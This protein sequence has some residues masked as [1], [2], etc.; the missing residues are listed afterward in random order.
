MSV[1]PCVRTRIN[2]VASWVW[3]WFSHHLCLQ[4]STSPTCVECIES[5]V[6]NCNT[7]RTLTSPAMAAR[8]TYDPSACV[9]V[10][11]TPSPHLDRRWVCLVLSLSKM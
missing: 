3:P 10:H 6:R 8:A 5:M 2:L 4:L 1:W 9:L 7:T 11:Y